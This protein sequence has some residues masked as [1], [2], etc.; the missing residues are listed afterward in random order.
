MRYEKGMKVSARRQI[1]EA[2][3]DTPGD[4]QAVF[5]DP[6]YIHA[7]AGDH[8]V[9]EGVCGGDPTVR[10]TRTGTSTIVSASEIEPL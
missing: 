9:V 8:G 2:G 4:P 1:T 10:F 6:A 5:P 3:V 7:E